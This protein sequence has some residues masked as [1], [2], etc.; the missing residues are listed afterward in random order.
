METNLIRA[1]EN[2]LPA[3]DGVNLGDDWAKE[4]VAVE[5]AIKKAK[6]RQKAPTRRERALC[7]LF[8]EFMEKVNYVLGGGETI[9]RFRKRYHRLIGPGGRG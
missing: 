2:L 7:K 1:V 9:E 4:I 8:E 6:A 3:F 5:R